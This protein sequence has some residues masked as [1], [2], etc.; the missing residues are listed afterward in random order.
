MPSP[1]LSGRR[2]TPFA[3]ASAPKNIDKMLLQFEGRENELIEILR[4]M[5]ERNVAQR[6]RAAVQKTTKLGA[7]AK[8]SISSVSELSGERR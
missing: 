6:A 3:P 8:A 7:R 5:H 1:P 4:T 2:L